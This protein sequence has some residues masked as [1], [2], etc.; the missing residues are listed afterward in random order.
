MS[1]NA[2]G[3]DQ[4]DADECEAACTG[5]APVLLCPEDRSA[6]ATVVGSGWWNLQLDPYLQ[7]PVRI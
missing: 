5:T 6:P 3:G 7:E 4:E 1:F 2:L